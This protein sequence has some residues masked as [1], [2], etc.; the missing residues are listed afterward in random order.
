MSARSSSKPQKGR[1]IRIS[2]SLLPLV[3]A[4]DVLFEDSDVNGPPLPP[5][6]TDRVI[7]Q[8]EATISL[9]DLC[10]D[11]NARYNANLS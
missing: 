7:K 8:G 2:A 11:T 1:G 3:K 4:D 6:A 5:S 9:S 10:D